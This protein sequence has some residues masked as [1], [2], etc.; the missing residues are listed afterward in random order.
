MSE[1]MRDHIDVAL[2]ARYQ[3][4]NALNPDHLQEVLKQLSP[5]SLP[6]G[7]TLFNKGD[8]DLPGNAS[9]YRNCKSPNRLR[10]LKT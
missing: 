3:P 10:Y 7:S 2:L 4:L 9:A 5:E 1:P 6:A 8:I